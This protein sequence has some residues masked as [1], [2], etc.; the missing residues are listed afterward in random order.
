MVAGGSAAW[1]GLA[2][3]E[4]RGEARLPPGTLVLFSR[5]PVS[6]H[7]DACPVCTG[8]LPVTSSILTRT[9]PVRGVG[10][11]PLRVCSAWP[12]DA[13]AQLRC[14]ASGAPASVPSLGPHCHLSRE[15]P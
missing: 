12:G 5:I 1:W 4:E 7:P 15:E 13:G 14:A 11:S 3:R 9:Q 10:A 2:H 8:A 6:S